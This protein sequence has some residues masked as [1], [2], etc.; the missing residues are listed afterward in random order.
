MQTG[1]SPII[2][3]VLLDVAGGDYWRQW[4]QF[5]RNQMLQRKLISPEDLCLFR[6]ADEREQATAEI[7][8]FYRLFHSSRFVE[9]KLVFR[10]RQPLA[11][12]HLAALQDDYADILLGPLEQHQGPLPAEGGEWPSLSRLIIPF[13]RSRYGRLRQLIDAINTAVSPGQELPQVPPG[14]APTAG[15]EALTADDS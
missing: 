1:K 11:D 15:Y 13:I 14:Q 10:L 7:C 3:V 12:D 5:I 4:E 2:P 6:V 9:D 8:G